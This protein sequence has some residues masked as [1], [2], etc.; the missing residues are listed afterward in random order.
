[1]TRPKTVV[2]MLLLLRIVRIMGGRPLLR[3][4]LVVFNLL[5]LRF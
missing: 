2:V 3:L 5:L 4:M 1:M